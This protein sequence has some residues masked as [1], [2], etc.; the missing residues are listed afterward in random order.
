MYDQPSKTCKLNTNVTSSRTCD[1]LHGTPE[2]DLQTCMDDGKLEW[3]F[4]SE[5]SGDSSQSIANPTNSPPGISLL[6]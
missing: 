6:I 2:P 4:E 5:G 1:I 3:E